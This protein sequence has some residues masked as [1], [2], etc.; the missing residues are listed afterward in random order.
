MFPHGYVTNREGTKSLFRCSHCP[1]A[2][3]AAAC[4]ADRSVPSSVAGC[5]AWLR[6]R[7]QLHSMPLRAVAGLGPPLRR[8]RPQ[9]PQLA[10][11]D[12]LPMERGGPGQAISSLLLETGQ[13]GVVCTGEPHGCQGAELELLPQ[14]CPQPGLAPRHPLP[15]GQ[16]LRWVLTL[17]AAGSSSR[18]P[19]HP[20]WLLAASHSLLLLCHPT[21][22]RSLKPHGTFLSGKE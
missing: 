3:P 22:L 14:L 13:L 4:S 10:A 20:A 15:L 11:P 1:A 9:E 5:C 17:P 16:P 12:S 21:C 2:A 18:T 19:Q 8:A 6:L 7:E